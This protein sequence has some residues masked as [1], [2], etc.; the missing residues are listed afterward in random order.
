M[1]PGVKEKRFNDL[2]GGIAY[3]RKHTEGFYL[4]KRIHIKELGLKHCWDITVDSEEHL[5]VL[6]NG[7]ICSNTKHLSG[8]FGKKRTYA[9]M[10]VITQLLQSPETFPHKAAVSA[11]A[12]RVENITDAPQGGKYIHVQGQE[13]YTPSGQEPTVK[14][15]DDVE[16]GDQL[17]DGIVDPYEIVKY[18][19]L[20]EGRRY[21][22]S[23]LK[24]AFKDSGLGEPMSLNLETIARGAL[25]HVRVDSPEGMGEYLPD[26]MASYSRMAAN[27][28]PPKDT[29]FVNTAKAVDKYLQVPAL[30]FTIGT[31]LTP[32]MLKHIS[33]AGISQVAVSSAEP[34]FVPDMVRLRAASHTEPDWMARL[35]SSYLGAGLENSAIRGKDTNTESNYS[36][37][38]RLAKGVGFGK[39][40]ERTGKF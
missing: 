5:F 15:G 24:E 29:A 14:S 35:G 6:A 26:D 37:I 36:V 10:D 4:A 34:A 31:K 39:T 16:A 8:K 38:P 1:I 9:G 23:R 21:Y 40:V 20:G 27:Y 3:Q 30:H 11:V 32:K 2:I 33:D 12:G 25:D 13:F 28:E 7:I 17:S 19:G 18:R 22:V